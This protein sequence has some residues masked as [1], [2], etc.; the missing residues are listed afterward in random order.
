MRVLVVDD[1]AET[2]EVVSRV[3]EREGH[4]ATAVASAQDALAAVRDERFDVVVVDVMLEQDSGLELC[5][6]MRRNGLDTPILFLS[7]RGAVRARVE[8][9]DAGGDDYLTKP[10]AV[11][12]LLARIQALGRRSP[13]L[14][15]KTLAFGGLVLDFEARRASGS[16]KELPIT[17]REW[18]IIRVL[19]DAGGRV[20]SFGDILERVWG[21]ASDG[22][23]ASLEVIVSRLRKKLE[24]AAGRKML[25]TVRGHGYALELDA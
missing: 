16:G 21:D 15:R 1:D 4:S 10:F 14:H 11:R 12:E 24:A 17:A 19:A 25:R 2:L 18:N 9:L 23:R 8:G 20:V 13:V 7:A 6:E 3:L 5:E 22:S